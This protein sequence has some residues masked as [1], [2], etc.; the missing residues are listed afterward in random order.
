MTSLAPR[1]NG[2]PPHDVGAEEAVLAALL[3]DDAAIFDVFGIVGPADFFREANRWIFEVAIGLAERGEPITLATVAH[4]LLE[5]GQLDAA[6]GEAYLV[7]LAGKYFT[8]V[9]APAHARIVARDARYRRMID[10]AG[11]IAQVAYRG[12][13]DAEAVLSAAEAL[14]RDATAG[15]TT[16]G[17][18]ATIAD[19]VERLR[20]PEYRARELVPTGLRPLDRLTGGFG[21][22]DLV[23]I[24]A[25]TSHGKTALAAQVALNMAIGGT[26]VAYLAVEGSSDKIAE[27]WCAML[28]GLTR[29]QAERAG[30]LPRY[31]AALDLLEGL[32]ITLVERDVTPRTMSAIASWITAAV[33]RA[34]VRVV[35]VDHIDAVDVE[36]A[37]GE[38]TAAGY[39]AGLRRLQN[40]AAR[41]NVAIVYLSQVNRGGEESMPSMR[42]LRESGAKEELAQLVLMLWLDYREEQQAAAQSYAGGAPA[43]FLW[44]KVEKHTEG[45]V[46]DVRGP[47][48]EGIAL[49]PLLLNL[50]SMTVAEVSPTG[51]ARPAVVQPGL[52]VG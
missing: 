7:E 52:G 14:L 26:P 43:R 12:G 39:H 16:A 47:V 50:R 10:A 11:R 28:A 20:N 1:G 32:P 2:L 41:E 35:F 21:R 42:S 40:T 49:P 48:V 45:Q 30:E 44:A 33:R 17:Q 9:G 8:A 23:C 36:R 19:V 46:G 37:P 3:L 22:G 5:R 25:H 29:E 51:A 27:R 18:F 38:S 34:G 24:G 15:S 13:P 31:L 4:E 6:G